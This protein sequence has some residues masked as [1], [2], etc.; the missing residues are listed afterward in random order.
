MNFEGR[1]SCSSQKQMFKHRGM[2]RV[3]IARLTLETQEWKLQELGL[4]HFSFT[5]KQLLA[6]QIVISPSTDSICSFFFFL[7]FF[8]S[9]LLLPLPYFAVKSPGF[10]LPCLPMVAAV[11]SPPFCSKLFA[12]AWG[13]WEH[14]SPS[15]SGHQSFW[16][17]LVTLL[18]PS[19]MQEGG[20]LLD[21][22]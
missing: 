8:F 2:K 1:G 12:Q 20:M 6:V 16:R 15:P 22:R 5:R 14:P 11:K 18:P 21:L 7:F 9:F 3:H 4:V 19:M 13:S 10:P 17:R